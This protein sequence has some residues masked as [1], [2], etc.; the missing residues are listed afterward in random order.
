MLFSQSVVIAL[1]ATLVTTFLGPLHAQETVTI[2][3]TSGCQSCRIQVTRG[4]AFGD[5]DGAGAIE[6]IESRAVQDSRGRF[7]LKGHY[8][9]ELKVYD[10]RGR[11]SGVIGQ[12]GGG[13]G[14][15]RGVG[16]VSVLPGD[17]LVVF[18]WESS[19]Y[20]LFSPA[21]KFVTSGP[22][23]LLPELGALVLSSGEFVF[24]A[25]V[26][27]AGEIGQPLHRVRRDGALAR[28][29]GSPT[30][31]YRPDIPFLMSRAIASARGGQL[32]SAYR[33]DYRIDL[34][35][36]Q[37]GRVVRSIHREA[38]WFPDGMRPTPRGAAATLDPKP[39]IFDV[40][41]DPEGRLWVLIA[42]ADPA[43]RQH[44]RFPGSSD[45]HGAILD[46]QRYY[47]T[48]VEVLDPDRRTVLASA[49]LGEHIKQFVGPGLLGT[50]LE[51]ADG[52][53]RFQTWQVRMLT[54]QPGGTP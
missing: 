40:Q 7:I 15:F 37:R 4:I 35:D 16:S 12:A 21:H 41:E 10:A 28:S 52:F 9:T 31:V 34:I 24:N 17:T 47:D 26:F 46:E 18:D 27:T 39:F 8:A 33:M 14:E 54:T 36:P 30:G 49:R 32:W 5:R 29:F 11:F 42:V 53:P 19:R 48:I 3:D 1:S 6:H 38:V 22:L 20:S 50:V 51:D 44:V 25:S 23:P 13:P 45:L 2:R 43:W